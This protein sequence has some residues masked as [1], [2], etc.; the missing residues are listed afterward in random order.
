MTK[1]KTRPDTEGAPPKS[2]VPERDL[3]GL[4]TL[5]PFERL[6]ALSLVDELL[7]RQTTE[8]RIGAAL[9][10]RYMLNGA[11]VKK[12]LAEAVEAAQVEVA[13][14]LATRRSVVLR[15]LQ[16]LYERAW[17]E[18]KLLVCAAVMKQIIEVEGHKRAD[19]LDIPLHDG[20]LSP[21]EADAATRSP[22]ELEHYAL[23]GLWPE[24]RATGKEPTQ[25]VGG[26]AAPVFPL[27]GTRH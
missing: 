22:A 24:E 23:H 2:W 15:G 16:R 8:R 27:G 13:S 10:E 18:G 4:A 17:S 11:A 25:V 9:R 19:R 21:W 7:L 26:G 1:P 5:T 14:A 3:R 20:E 6:E 12:L